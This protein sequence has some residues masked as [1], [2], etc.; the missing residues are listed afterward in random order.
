MKI[1]KAKIKVSHANGGTEYVY[2]QI[3]LDNVTEIPMIV[4]PNDRT[5]EVSESGE[6]YQICYPVVP[7]ELQ[8]QMLAEHPEI[9]SVAEKT[10]FEA[11][12]DKHYP[13]KTIITDTDKVLSILAKSA[14]GETLTKKDK[15]AL[16]PQNET[17]GVTLSKRT[18][19]IATIDYGATF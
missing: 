12:A 2:P 11:Y 19:D 8:T 18:A 17:T 14:T 4:Y 9:F 16:D 1:I 10:E 3:W 13:Q 7:D 6:T 5:D 15:D